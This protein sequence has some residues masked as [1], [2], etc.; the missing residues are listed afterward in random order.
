MATLVVISQLLYAKS[1][2]KIPFF[3]RL[4]DW[5]RLSLSEDEP[6]FLFKWHCPLGTD[7]SAIGTTGKRPLRWAIRT[8]IFS[9]FFL[10]NIDAQTWFLIGT[11]SRFALEDSQERPPAEVR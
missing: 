4:H 2:E 10:I 7:G 11:Y 5:T 3:F 6:L 9:C 1:H 8:W